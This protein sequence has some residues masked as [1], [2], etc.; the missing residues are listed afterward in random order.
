MGSNTR[1]LNTSGGAVA[2][3]SALT[4]QNSGLK[5]NQ[6]WSKEQKAA[7]DYLDL[8]FTRRMARYLP[9]QWSDLKTKPKFMEVIFLTMLNAG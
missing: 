9:E 5:Q 3:Q 4:N 8:E 1:L 6:E 2:S 7:T